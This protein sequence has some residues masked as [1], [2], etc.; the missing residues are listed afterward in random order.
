MYATGSFQ[1]ISNSKEME[2]EGGY[3]RF[4]LPMTVSAASSMLADF[5][6]RKYS[7]VI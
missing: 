1:L 5:P 2:L 4:A 7:I 3:L 6:S